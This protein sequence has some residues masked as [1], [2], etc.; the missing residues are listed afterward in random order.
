MQD[1]CADISLQ[2][3]FE[4]KTVDEAQG[5]FSLPHALGFLSD[6]ASYLPPSC[7]P[8]CLVA[9]PGGWKVYL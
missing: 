3:H 6:W 5:T 9:V 4:S 2:T 1:H 7:L 8:G